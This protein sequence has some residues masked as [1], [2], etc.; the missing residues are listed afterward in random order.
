MLKHSQ[1]NH[2]A[3]VPGEEEWALV[4][5]HRG[6]VAKLDSVQKKLFDIAP[7]LREDQPKCLACKF[8][9][10]CLGGCPMQRTLTGEPECPSAL[11]DPDGYALRCL[12]GLHQEP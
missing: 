12:L 6:T 2:L 9:P 8:L 7:S 1:F 5:F 4:N 3:Q 11:F 10:C